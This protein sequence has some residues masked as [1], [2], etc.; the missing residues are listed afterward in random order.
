MENLDENIAK[1]IK[2]SYP[3]IK[4]FNPAQKAV[5]DSGYIDD[6]S[7]YIIAIPTASGK[8]VL[9]VLGLLKSLINGSKAIYAVPLVSIQNEKI[10]EFKKFE[11]FGIKV[12]RHPSSSD[13]AVMVFESFD[14]LTR[15][16]WN[17]LRD[18]DSIVIDEF[19]MIGEDSRGPTIECALTRSRIINPSM[20]IIALS[21]TLAN[22]DD[23]K[24]WLNGKVIEHDYRPVPLKKQV[25]DNEM[26]NVKTKNDVIVKIIEKAKKENSQALSFVSTRRFTE[27]LAKYVSLKIKTKITK[28]VKEK[29][30]EVAEKLLDVPKRKGSRPTTTCINLAESAKYGCVFHHAGLFSEQKEIIEDEFRAG[31][32]LMIVATPSLMYGVNLPSKSVIIRDYTR[33]TNQGPQSIP[34]FDYEQMSGRAGRPLYDKEGYS[35]LLAKTAEEAKNL[36]EMYV[37]GLIE[38]TNSKL[39]ENKDAFYKQIIAQVASSIS[40]NP[41]ELF[42]FFKKTL[43]GYQ[44]NKNESLSFFAEETLKYEIQSS[45]EY[46]MKNGILQITP[47]GLKASEFGLLIAKS[48]YAVN[49]AIKIKEYSNQLDGQLNIGELIYLMAQTVDLPL[50]S[51]KAGKNKEPIIEKMTSLGIFSTET[52][53]PEAT[54]VS[55][56]EWINEK[57][58]YEIE[59]KYNVY[60]ASCRRCALEA[61][62]LIK[63]TKDTF[64]VFGEYKYIND[65]NKLSARLYYGVKEDIIPLVLGVKRLGRKRARAAVETFGEDLRVASIRDLQ[66]IDGI[67]PKLAE[68]IKEFADNYNSQ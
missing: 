11:E 43:Y 24:N 61:S 46:L 27:S 6:K 49:T 1:I 51:R 32:I 26:F 62:M 55:L 16:N 65:L 19:H 15:Y 58:E 60:S 17:V 28:K 13:L 42:D 54:C 59:N 52:G 66:R 37:N 67:G 53:N 5:L 14:S 41:D 34:V 25:L 50:I 22:M 29:F 68:R 64:E 10:N 38:D 45:I 23:I 31:N 3:Y 9:G 7:N 35:Y 20:R 47:S 30:E 12:G 40:K 33:W 21:A 18:I 48:N 44:M 56:I 57:T 4:E 63:F 8:T 36:E 2:A 39:I